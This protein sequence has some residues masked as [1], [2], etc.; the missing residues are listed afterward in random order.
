MILPTW[1]DCY[2]FGSRAEMLG[3]GL[4]G[5]KTAR[6]RWT[7]KE[8]GPVLIETVLGP[9]AE[10]MRQRAREIQQFCKTEGGGRNVAAR[11]IMDEI[12]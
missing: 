4:W 3:I 9:R 7:A 10:S 1:V 12:A 8:L 2:E 11:I 5:N 6:P